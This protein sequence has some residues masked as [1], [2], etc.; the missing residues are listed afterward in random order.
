[1]R[2]KNVNN[3]KKFEVKMMTIL[4]LLKTFC[5]KINLYSVP[6]LDISKRYVVVF[7]VGILIGKIQLFVSF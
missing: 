3:W 5:K 7:K 6:C 4:V 1:M 2:I